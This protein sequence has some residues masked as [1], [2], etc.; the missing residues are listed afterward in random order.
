ME[1]LDYNFEEKFELICESIQTADFIAI[2]LELSG[3]S[4]GFED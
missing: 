1:I 4:V 3:L 2:D